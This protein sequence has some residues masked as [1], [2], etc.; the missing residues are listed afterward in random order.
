MRVSANGD[1][2]ELM[3]RAC[4]V[5][6]IVLRRLVKTLISADLAKRSHWNCTCTAAG[7]FCETFAAAYYSAC[8]QEALRGRAE[9]LSADGSHVTLYCD[10]S[11]GQADWQ[12]E[13]QL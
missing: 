7:S 9:S 8:D 13:I 6:V 10:V 3:P 12:N 2:I 1:R 5:N 11:F 4:Q